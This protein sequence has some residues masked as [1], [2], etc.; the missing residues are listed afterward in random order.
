MLKSLKAWAKPILGYLDDLVLIPLGMKLAL[1]MTPTS[2][3]DEAGAK[4][5]ARVAK[6]K[7]KNWLAAGIIILVW[8][9]VI[10]SIFWIVI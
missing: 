7:P 5:E 6:D 9:A 8:I 4:A 2:V 3:L 1:K 10:L